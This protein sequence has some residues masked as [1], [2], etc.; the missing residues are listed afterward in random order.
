MSV[1]VII[2]CYNAGEYLSDCISSILQQTHPV[3]EIIVVDDGSTDTTALIARDF[4]DPVRVMGQPNMG[5][6]TARNNGIKNSRGDFV[7]FI[8]ADD[9]WEPAKLEQQVA[10][11]MQNREAAAVVSGFTMFGDG[12][13]TIEC[14]VS[15]RELLTQ[16][17]IDFLAFPAILLSTL[18]VRSE[19]AKQLSF[20]ADVRDGEDLIYMAQVRTYGFIGAVDAL[21]A[22]R[23]QHSGQVTKSARH[24]ARS[25]GARLAWAQDNFRKI[26]I[27]SRDLAEDAMCA[28]AL[29]NVMASYWTRDL[30]RFK[31][32]RRELVQAWPERIPVPRELTR[33]VP[34]ATLFKV[35][36]FLDSFSGEKDK[37]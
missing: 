8:D 7:A 36:D 11:M 26:G 27:E 18:L 19:V 1:S 37:P 21:L 14:P 5:V 10:Y 28:G 2:P 9:L 31:A 20:P 33:F 24:F 32:W 25:F 35:K 29:K 17:A 34:P 12:M 22:R 4:G 15:N 30:R 23:R 13:E 16:Q 3:Q 6:S